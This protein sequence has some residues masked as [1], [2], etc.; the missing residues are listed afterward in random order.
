MV[1]TALV[2]LVV[3]VTGLPL[4][5]LWAA[6]APPRQSNFTNGGPVPQLQ[7]VYHW[8]DPV[9][10]FLLIGFTAG[11]VFGVTLWA[12]LRRR[13]GPVIVL[14]G[15]LGSLAAAWLAIRFGG[16]VATIAHPLPAAPRPGAAI[17]VAP[18]VDTLWAMLAQ[19]LGVAVAYGLAAS[20]NGF[21]DLGRGA[22]PAEDAPESAG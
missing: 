6:L 4:G 7:T 1:P 2:F 3:A 14:A 18:R 8:F 22:P 15:A 17:A 19:P 10:I 11:L 12:L 9:A 5:G 21:D 13:R 16:W 20:W